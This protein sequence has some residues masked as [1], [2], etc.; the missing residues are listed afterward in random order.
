MI[1][2]YIG[3]IKNG[4]T[5]LEVIIDSHPEMKWQ[6]RQP[7]SHTLIS[8]KSSEAISDKSQTEM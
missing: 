8:D 2:L 1:S 4:E 3:S 6:M 5:T 7:L